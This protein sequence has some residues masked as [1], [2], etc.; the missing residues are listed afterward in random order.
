MGCCNQWS[1]GQHLIQH[2]SVCTEAELAQAG[3]HDKPSCDLAHWSKLALR[4]IHPPDFFRSEGERGG[5]RIRVEDLNID[6]LTVYRNQRTI[7]D[8]RQGKRL[9]RTGSLDCHLRNWRVVVQNDR[10]RN[11]DCRWVVFPI[12]RG[13]VSISQESKPDSATSR[14]EDAGFCLLGHH[15]NMAVQS[16]VPATSRDFGSQLR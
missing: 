12:L 2:G 13:A 10:W 8:I 5:E 14:V 9:H 1:V 3:Y 11:E 7:L 4:S 16:V 15:L 6:G